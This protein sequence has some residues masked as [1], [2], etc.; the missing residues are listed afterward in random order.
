[1]VKQGSDAASKASWSAKDG[2]PPRGKRDKIEGVVEIPSRSST[3]VFCERGASERRAEI[4]LGSSRL[5]LP[6]KGLLRSLS[7]VSTIP[8]AIKRLAGRKGT[9]L[10]PRPGNG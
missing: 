6:L 1:M 9:C 7:A 5:L 4:L 2:P 10:A 8:Q 3:A